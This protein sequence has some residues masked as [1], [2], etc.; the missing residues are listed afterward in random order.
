MNPY[1]IIIKY[2]DFNESEISSEPKE[3]KSFHLAKS[4]NESENKNSVSEKSC[5]PIEIKLNSETTGV[6][7]T[8][9]HKSNDEAHN[10]IQSNGPR[11]CFAPLEENV[12][13]HWKHHNPK[14][15]KE[16]KLQ[17]F[18]R[19]NNELKLI[20]TKTFVW[21]NCPEMA[22]TQFNGSLKSIE[23]NDDE[24]NNEGLETV[25]LEYDQQLIND[26]FP[27]ECVTAEFSPY[28]LMLTVVPIS[29][30]SVLN[31]QSVWMYFDILVHDIEFEWCPDNYLEKVLPNPN[32]TRNIA[33]YRSLTDVVDGE[34]FNGRIP[35][36]GE[37]KKVYLKS[38]TF[39][40]TESELTN[41]TY[42]NRYKELW[43]D[44]PMI[45]IFAKAKIRKS[46]KQGVEAKF[47][48][49]KMKF[50]WE[51]VDKADADYNLTGL[52]RIQTWVNE[53]RDYKTQR[54]TDSPEG[55]NCHVDRGGKRGIQA[56]TCF[57]QQNGKAPT[58]LDQLNNEFP[59]KIEPWNDKNLLFTQRR[60]AAYSDSWASGVLAGKTGVLFQP[61]RMAGDG[62]ELHVYLAY[63]TDRMMQQE[64]KENTMPV[65]LHKKTGTFQIWREL[66]I[67]TH[68]RLK[69]ESSNRGRL[70][71]L[72]A[73]K[74]KFA[75]YYIKLNLPPMPRYDVEPWF[76]ALKE[77]WNETQLDSYIRLAMNPDDRSSLVSFIPYSEWFDKMVEIKGS[78]EALF[79]WANQQDNGLDAQGQPRRSSWDV[80]TG[81][82]GMQPILKPWDL[83]FSENLNFDEEGKVKIY[84]PQLET[85]IV[86]EFSKNFSINRR[87]DITPENRNILKNF[88]RNSLDTFAKSLGEKGMGSYGRGKAPENH[89]ALQ[90]KL[91]GM[92]NE[93]RQQSRLSNIRTAI[94]KIVPELAYEVGKDTYENTSAGYSWAFLAFDLTLNKLVKGNNNTDLEGI[95]ALQVTDVTNVKAPT[96]KAFFANAAGNRAFATTLDK[97]PKQVT[98]EHE[99]GH[100]MF[101]NHT[102]YSSY[103]HVG[104]K[105]SSDNDPLCL[106]QGPETAAK[107]E[108]C[109]MHRTPSSS[110]AD[111]SLFC[112]FCILRLWGW[113]FQKINNDGSINQAERTIWYDSAYNQNPNNLIGMPL[114]PVE[115]GEKQSEII[116]VEGN[117]TMEGQAK[118]TITSNLIANNGKEILV[119]VATGDT[120]NSVAQKI[121]VALE[122]D[123]EVNGLFDLKNFENR[124][125]LIVK[126]P[127]ANDDTL[128]I[129]VENHTCEGLTKVESKSSDKGSLRLPHPPLD[130][131]TLQP[132]QYQLF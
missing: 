67:S 30:T 45:P 94:E 98:F 54:T 110:C 105:F 76:K 121:K 82:S 68:W 57:P 90:I 7:S 83:S 39:Y 112:G 77:V 103:P 107:P 56:K 75:K 73:T 126:N 24:K 29:D 16:S 25:K 95:A 74:T 69:S 48:L 20:W 127:G 84:L 131:E 92:L 132:I 26:K 86:I 85:S 63:D 106:H 34:N 99:I 113:S 79:N 5:G 35:A 60:W 100:A 81:G 111:T 23:N 91:Y 109:I 18:C 11:Y 96:G 64:A 37:K 93:G 19:I 22:K 65:G 43:G 129:E 36:P 104:R 102:H 70:L 8:A 51:W 88:M 50:M 72:V 117:V 108:T 3:V 13:I 14:M 47:G 1:P 2:D 59:F 38:H 12:W 52:Q 21:D 53:T 124:I 32:K 97:D 122:L 80:G 101:L 120:Q 128:K 42:Y 115:M 130:K 9:F 89:V 71:D 114:H 58:E 116:Y 41:L 15:I 33:M 62:Y 6:E 44:G 55:K 28:K 66:N 4:T 49:G 27:G 78:K 10:D 123:N 31:P 87:T 61:S 17:L 118:V 125:S 40:K 119:A 46:N